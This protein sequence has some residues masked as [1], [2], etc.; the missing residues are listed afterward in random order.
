[1]K[2]DPKVAE[3]VYNRK[4]KTPLEVL[5]YSIHVSNI[6]DSDKNVGVTKVFDPRIIKTLKDLAVMD[7]DI[8]MGKFVPVP[9]IATQTMMIMLDKLGMLKE[10]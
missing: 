8:V 6:V 2:I 10:E 5:G 3:K 9:T 1:M 7:K 4:L